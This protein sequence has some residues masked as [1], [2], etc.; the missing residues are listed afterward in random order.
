MFDYICNTSELFLGVTN[1]QQYE[2][3]CYPVYN[4]NQ[5]FIAPKTQDSGTI[6]CKKKYL[7]DNYGV[8]IT[9]AVPCNRMVECHDGRDEIGC[10]FPPWLIPSLLSGAGA[11]LNITLFVHLYKSIGS[12]WKK[13]MQYRKSRFSFQRRHLSIESEKLY[14]MAVLIES[15]N[16]DKIHKL[17]CQVL[18]NNEDE[19]EATCYFKVM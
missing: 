8:G 17:Y 15:G 12:T 19:G 9:W 16:I 7:L 11:V 3:S 6:L 2:V 18:E 1:Q 5:T 13:K 14:K 10:E 4:T